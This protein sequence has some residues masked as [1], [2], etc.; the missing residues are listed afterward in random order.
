EPP[1]AEH[2]PEGPEAHDLEP[3][4]AV[5]EPAAP[6][7]HTG[8][9]GAGRSGPLA[10]LLF[11][12]TV[13]A[14]RSELDQRTMEAA[15]LR[16]RLVEAQRESESRSHAESGLESAHAE[17][18]AELRH[19]MGAVGEQRREFNEQLAAAH[20][21]RDLAREERDRAQG[22]RDHAHGERDHARE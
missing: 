12:E 14:L 8:E 15:Q 11:K 18:R 16:A 20:A 19:L 13:T 17:L 21:E 10:E 2:V 7:P 4:V 6:A 3:V 22:E 1:P 5:P 9:G